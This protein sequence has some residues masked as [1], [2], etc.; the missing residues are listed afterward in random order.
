MAE[1]RMLNVG[2]SI[3][4]WAIG[5]RVVSGIAGLL[6]APGARKTTA[7]LGMLNPGIVP[8]RWSAGCA[9]GGDRLHVFVYVN[10][11]YYLRA[12][13]GDGPRR[14]LRAESRDRLSPCRELIWRPGV[15]HAQRRLPGN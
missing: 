4:Y 13:R 15:T 3:I 9:T 2:D 5:T 7:D 10:Y 1:R 8:R 12:R 14:A 6:L 11:D